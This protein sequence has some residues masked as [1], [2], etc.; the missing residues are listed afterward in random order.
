MF[1]FLNL[2]QFNENNYK[3][4]NYYLLFYLIIIYYNNEYNIEY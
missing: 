4:L 2:I 1:I 3:N